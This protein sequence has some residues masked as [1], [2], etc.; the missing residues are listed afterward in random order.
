MCVRHVCEILQVHSSH[1]SANG[2]PKAADHDTIVISD[3]DEEAKAFQSPSAQV[4]GSVGH[5]KLGCLP[6]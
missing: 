4:N 3:S 5:L 6:V 2:R 1:S